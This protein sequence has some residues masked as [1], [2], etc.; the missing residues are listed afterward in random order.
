MMEQ[1]ILEQIKKFLI[2][3]IDPSF[4][5]LFGSQATGITH[6]ES[7]IDIAFYKPNHEQ[8]AYDVFALAQE[9][10]NLIKYDVDLVD[11]DKASTV[12]KA[13]IFS[14]GNPIYISEQAELDKYRMNAMSIY[15]NLN[16]ERKEI[17]KSIIESGTIYDNKK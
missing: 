13:Q 4:I 7:D 6:S 1:K 8:S 14:T 17:L 15:A 11:L 16:L 10:A 3:K 12:F 2:K 5:V 9:L